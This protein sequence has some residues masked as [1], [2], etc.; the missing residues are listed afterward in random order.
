MMAEQ[1]RHRHY[2]VAERKQHHRA[3]ELGDQLGSQTLLHGSQNCSTRAD[4]FA[5]AGWLKTRDV[6]NFTIRREHA[7]AAS[8]Y[9]VLK[10]IAAL[11]GWSLA[12][13]TGL[14]RPRR[15]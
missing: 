5:H 3:E 13:L 2:T 9:P 12:W 11:S 15:C 4:G 1:Q 8:R 6:R 10:K 7:A 14:S